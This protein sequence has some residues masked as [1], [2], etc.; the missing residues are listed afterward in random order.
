MKN[1]LF[2]TLL[3]A[4]LLTVATFLTACGGNADGSDA[5][6]GTEN[7][8]N[9]TGD[10]YK[11]AIVKYVDDASLNQI[12]DA[13]VAQLEAKE[14]E[15]GVN[16]DIEL[17]NGQ[18]DGTVLNQIAADVV[19]EQVDAVIPIATP[20]AVLMQAAT[21]DTDIPVVFSAVSDPVGAGLVA[22]NEAPG[23]NVTGT[24][25]AIDTEAIMNLILLE[26][27]DIQKIG[28]LYDKGQASS[29]GSIADAIAFCKAHNIEVVEKTGTNVNEI[30]TA[31]DV[32]VA[33]KVEAI[34]TPQDNTVMTAEL[35][36][37]EKFVDAE[38][39]HYTGADSFALNG[40]FLGYGVNYEKLGIL[41]ADMVIDIV[42]NGASPAETAVKTLD[43][44]ILTVNTETADALEIDYS[45]FKDHC[46]E[47]K[48]IQTGKEF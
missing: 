40:A 11:I 44:G 22:T 48:E 19:A 34:F 33:E 14:T 6:A 2:K 10:T 29:L 30:Q 4:T 35:A 43:D 25:D 16:F 47:L 27:P 7:S 20:A 3:T 13:I 21:E 32:L 26:N 39:P 38:I 45:I 18:A 46:D 23:S 28:L 24:S 5:G 41:T 17:Y 8:A 15:L 12:E 1:K 31:A 36:I 9:N 42:V 37:Y